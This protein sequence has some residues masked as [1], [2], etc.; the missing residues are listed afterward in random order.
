MNLTE[1]N[2]QFARFEQ[3]DTTKLNGTEIPVLL[4]SITSYTP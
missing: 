2:C 4:I 1:K 3:I